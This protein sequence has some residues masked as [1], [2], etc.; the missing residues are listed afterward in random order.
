VVAAP[1]YA[2]YHNTH[3]LNEGRNFYRLSAI[4]LTRQW[5]QQSEVPLPLVG[6]DEG[7]ALAAAFYGPDHPLYEQELVCPKNKNELPKAAIISRGWAALCFAEDDACIDRTRRNA[8]RSPRIL[9]SEFT[10]QSALIGF[11][12]A[13]QRIKGFIIPPVR[14]DMISTLSPDDMIERRCKSARHGDW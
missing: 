4:E 11:P 1:L 12:G 5:H 8:S 10:V 6:G 7:L 2:W 3:P 9:E 14:E 13:Q